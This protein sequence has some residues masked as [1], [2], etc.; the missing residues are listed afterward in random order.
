MSYQ[1]ISPLRPKSSCFTLNVFRQVAMGYLPPRISSILLLPMLSLSGNV[2]FAPFIV[3]RQ[4]DRI[5][6]R[7]CRL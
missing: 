6:F 7:T 5:S 1:M 3:A 2:I 4:V